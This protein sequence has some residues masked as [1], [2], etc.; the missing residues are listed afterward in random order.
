M[1]TR[2]EL[3]RTKKAKKINAKI[4]DGKKLTKRE[5]IFLEEYEN[6]HSDNEFSVIVGLGRE[7]TA[8]D[9][10]EIMKAIEATLRQ[11]GYDELDIAP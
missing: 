7:M 2:S 4:L 8:E 3:E 10:S 11:K 1:T 5:N 6:T 9:K